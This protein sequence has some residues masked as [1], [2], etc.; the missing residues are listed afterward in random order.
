MALGAAAQPPARNSRLELSRLQLSQTRQTGECFSSCFFAKESHE[1][2][3]QRLSKTHC[4]VGVGAGQQLEGCKQDLQGSGFSYPGRNTL[5]AAIAV[6]SNEVRYKEARAAFVVLAPLR[7]AHGRH[8]I[9]LKKGAAATLQL[10]RAWADGDWWADAGLLAKLTSSLE[11]LA[12]A[13]LQ[14]EFPMPPDEA[15]AWCSGK[16]R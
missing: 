14:V 12:Q 10:Y 6:L 1:L 9:E 3:G 16:T 7:V 15:E 11:S 2:R 13:G 5:H 8:L 4:H